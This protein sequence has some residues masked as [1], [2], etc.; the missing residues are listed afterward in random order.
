MRSGNERKTWHVP[1]EHLKDDSEKKRAW[2]MY[3]VKFKRQISRKF[4][5]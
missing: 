5:V 4:S 3:D 1:N 2:G